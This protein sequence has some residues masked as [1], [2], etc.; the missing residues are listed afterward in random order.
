[1][2]S[3]DVSDIANQPL[4]PSRPEEFHGPSQV[5]SRAVG[6]LKWELPRIADFGGDAWSACIRR[7]IS[8]TIFLQ[9][10]SPKLCWFSDAGDKRGSAS[11]TDRRPKSAKARSR[12]K[13]GAGQAAGAMRIQCRCRLSMVRATRA[14]ATCNVC[15]LGRRGGNGC[16]VVPHNLVSESGLA[17]RGSG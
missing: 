13:L 6:E 15:H 5:G 10:G 7:R 8:P 11:S 16:L 12:G 9:R 2:S 4:M 3:G 17:R 1:M 14:G